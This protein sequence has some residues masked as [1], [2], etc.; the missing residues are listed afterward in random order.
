MY[1]SDKEIEQF[2]R[3]T[4]A[5]KHL[6]TPGN[7]ENNRPKVFTAFLNTCE[8]KR[9]AKAALGWGNAPLVIVR[10][11]LIKL[12]GGGEACGVYRGTVNPDS[13]EISNLRVTPLERCTEVDLD[14]NKI[15]FECTLLHELV[16]WVRYQAGLRDSD[17]DKFPDSPMEAGGQFE[18]WAYG[19]LQCTTDE[20][21][22]SMLTYR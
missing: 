21:W 17:W 10:E 9:L 22:Q 6:L 12:P 19:E 1:W 15:R 4:V 13:V 16:H 8:N 5:M 20:I 14:A 7:L 3:S 2:P 18:Y 11:G